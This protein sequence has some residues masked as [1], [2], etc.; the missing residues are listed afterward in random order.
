MLTG[1]LG[2]LSNKQLRLVITKKK[3]FQVIKLYYKL[4]NLKTIQEKSNKR[5]YI[6]FISFIPDTEICGYYQIVK[7]AF[8][9]NNLTSLGSLSIQPIPPGRMAHMA[10]FNMAVFFFKT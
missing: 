5:N 2:V 6:L 9:Y 7:I 10:Y 1:M 4:V 8:E 3:V